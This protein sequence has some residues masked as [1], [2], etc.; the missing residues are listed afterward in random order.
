[1]NKKYG[2]LVGKFLP[3]HRGH[4]S[5]IF[6]SYTQ[7]DKLY[8]V[9]CDNVKL[10]TRLS[11]ENGLEYIP[12][13]TR[14]RW[15]LTELKGFDN[16]NVSIL[17]ESD[18]VA[19]YPLGW[20]QWSDELKEHLKV[21][22]DLRLYDSIWRQD[23]DVIIFTGE[24]NDVL[25]YQGYFP[26]CEVRF[27]DKTMTRYPIS[28]TLIRKQPL[29]YWDYIAGS[30]RKHYAKK[31]LITGTESCGKTTL[32]KAMAK[33]FHTSWAE[34]MGRIY[35][36]QNVKDERYITDEDYLNIINLQIEANEHALKTCNKICFFDTD[37]VVTWYYY[38][39]YA[40]EMHR[41][42]G[43][44]VVSMINTTFNAYYKN[45][46]DK[47]YMLNPDVPWIPDGYRR[48]FN[49]RKALNAELTMLYYHFYHE[50]F[51]KIDFLSGNYNERWVKVYDD[52]IQML[53]EVK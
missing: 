7:V 9:V 39:L 8:I 27:F 36:E 50:E 49:D 12:A 47:I 6:N 32:T 24:P 28:G 14:M 29:K 52:I 48:H 5:H 51:V 4:L 26:G 40:K 13:S 42:Y 19:E 31:I 18:L 21:E 35:V 43:E 20:K 3:L 37:I 41:E 33:V 10:D 53:G 1:M 2:I 16:I 30:A 25:S 34:E 15:L 38:N 46:Y 23:H 22:Y 17:K 11:V 45:M 44:S